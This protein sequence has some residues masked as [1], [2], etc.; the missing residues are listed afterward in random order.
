MKHWLVIA[1]V[2]LFTAAP[3]RSA[4]LE[5]SY[6]LQIVQTASGHILWQTPV[7]VDEFFT[8]SYTHSSAHTPVQDL[9][10]VESKG[11]LFLLEESYLWYGAGLPFHPKD[12]TIDFSGKRV[13]A[14]MHRYFPHFLLR[15]GTVANHVLTV[16]GKPL[17]LLHI[18]KG[19]ERVWIRVVKQTT[20]DR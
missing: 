6:L 20:L 17:P 11:R 19:R 15:V 1:S 8:L 10:R 16:H 12:G 3:A 13:R 4:G 7:H 9:F 14:R 18:A 2:L 5:E